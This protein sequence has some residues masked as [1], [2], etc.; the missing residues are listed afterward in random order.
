MN[1]N[2]K[3]QV[4][5]FHFK[6]GKKLIKSAGG[7]EALADR[8]KFKYGSLTIEDKN[9]LLY[10]NQNDVR[11]MRDITKRRFHSP[12]AESHPSPQR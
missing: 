11:S 7:I 4:Q 1:K 2:Q 3:T 5:E 10:E 9:K 8:I 6:Q 12:M